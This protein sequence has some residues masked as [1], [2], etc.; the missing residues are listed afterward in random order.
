MVKVYDIILTFDTNKSNDQIEIEIDNLI[1][2]I[3]YVL[4]RSIRDSLPQI[5][6][7]HD[8]KSKISIVPIK[9]D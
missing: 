1:E 9:L 3:N 5:Y 6:K 8:K 4:S 2:S 7:D